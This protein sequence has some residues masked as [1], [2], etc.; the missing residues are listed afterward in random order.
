MKRK[1][2]LI[3]CLCLLALSSQPPSRGQE[4]AK[5]QASHDERLQ[6]LREHSVPVASIDPSDGDFS[7]L[8]PLVARIGKSRVVLL[9]EQTHGDGA[10]FLAK[11]RLIRFLHQVMGFD[12]LAW[13]SGMFGCREMDAALR[14]TEPVEKAAAKGIYPVWANSGHVRPLFEYVRL[15]YGTP[16]PL[17]MAGFDGQISTKAAESLQTEVLSLIDRAD[18]RL[19]SAPQRE[20]LKALLGNFGEYRKLTPGER[21]TRRA[22]VPELLALFEQNRERLVA[23][24]SPRDL[25]F[26]QQ[27]LKNL[28]VFLQNLETLIAN[29]YRVTSVRDNNVRDQKMGE[30]LV[31][32]AKER[33]PDRKLIVWA[34]SFHNARNTPTIDTMSKPSPQGPGLSYDGLVTMGHVAHAALGDEFYSIAFV[35]YQGKAGIVGRDP[36]PLPPAPEG[37]LDALLHELGPLYQFVDF[38]SLRAQPAHWLR[39]PLISRPLGNMPMQT[40]WTRIFDGLFYTETMFPSTA[41]GEVP[42]EIKWKRE[43]K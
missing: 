39:Q 33:Y 35:A 17:E 31:W 20:K 19:L 2:C 9:G 21:Q 38:R 32:L 15:T 40:D 43:R 8:M 16:R 36:S 23:A 29:N 27:C 1:L 28:S 4:T 18:P 42:E 6:W 13:E 41:T 5:P 10:T 22:I 37:S 14:T 25:A 26:L 12:V 11:T 24:S 3:F 7:D 34:A 30:N